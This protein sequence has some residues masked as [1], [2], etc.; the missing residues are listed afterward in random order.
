MAEHVPVLC[1]PVVAAFHRELAVAPVVDG[2]CGYGGHSQALLAASPGLR[3]VGIDRDP[4]AVAAATERLRGYGDRAVVCHGCFGDWPHVLQQLGLG[5]ASGLLLDL[6][7]SSPQLDVPERGFSFMRDGP[8]D[9]RMG[10]DS[11]STALELLAETS[12][13]DLADILWRF[14]EERHSR[15]VA[16]AIKRR[17]E[18]GQLR[19]TRDLA[20][21]CADAYPRGPQRIDPATRTFQAIRIA[22]NDE[23]GELERALGHCERWLLS[24]GAVAVISFHSLEDRIIKLKFRQWQARELGRILKPDHVT[25]DDSERQANPRSRSAKLRVF[26]WGASDPKG[27]PKDKYRS[28]KH[29]A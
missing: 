3:V 13:A 29:R 2:T 12:E 15:R 28:K 10:D 14:G 17:L 22:V 4:R 16:R 5:G 23:L 8:L 19:T 9:M 1:G 27:D 21:I 24:P 6:G 26:L 18:E 20:A 25:A 11:G 7:V